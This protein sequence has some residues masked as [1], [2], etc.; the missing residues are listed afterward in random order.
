MDDLTVSDEI[1][2]SSSS[3]L[4]DYVAM[5]KDFPEQAKEAFEEFC[6]RFQADVLRMA[7]IACTRWNLSEVVALDIAHCTF[8]RV[9]KYP[10]FNLKKSIASDETKAIQ[11]WLNGIIMTQL[12]NQ[13]NNGTC[14]E[15]TQ[16]EDL[17]IIS[18]TEELIDYTCNG[19]VE[20]KKNLRQ[21]LEIVEKG[22]SL[23][24]E[25]H[26]IIYL[27]YKA[28]EKPKKRL[29]RSVLEKLRLMLNLT[30]NSV[31][32]YKNEANEIINKYLESHGKN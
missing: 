4:I 28:Y 24:K 23:L 14:H 16:D 25:K 21:A 30:Q 6:I 5:K 11:F 32:V 22:L 20:Q 3:D 18:S 8:D 9:W 1:K 10:S 31:K 26:R 2:S 27:T 29:P 19:D 17:S 15:P 13:Y 12:A 7:E